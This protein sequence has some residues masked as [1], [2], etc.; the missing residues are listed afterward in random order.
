M[1]SLQFH[2]YLSPED[3]CNIFEISPIFALFTPISPPTYIGHWCCGAGA[4]SEAVAG[5]VSGAV[6]GAAEPES[7]SVL[8]LEPLFCSIC[9]YL[10]S[11]IHWILV[12]WS[13]NRFRSRGSRFPL[14]FR[15]YS[16]C[17]AL[18]APIFFPTYIGYCFF[19]GA[20]AISGVAVPIP[21]RLRL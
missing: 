20:G 5:V 11:N 16:R 6:S 9:S 3:Y 21:R 14:R 19:C 2:H 18:F 10:F 7:V 4:V 8:A 17:F 1:T 13:R 12:L 15:L